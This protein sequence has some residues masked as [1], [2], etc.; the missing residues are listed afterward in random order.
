MKRAISLNYQLNCWFHNETARLAANGTDS[1]I[2]LWSDK[3]QTNDFR[4]IIIFFKLTQWIFFSSKNK[5]RN[6]LSLHCVVRPIENQPR[7]E[8]CISF[9]YSN[10]TIIIQQQKK[11]TKTHRIFSVWWKDI[12]SKRLVINNDCKLR[13]G[14]K[15]K[16]QSWFDDNDWNECSRRFECERNG[17]SFE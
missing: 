8:C 13:M 4:N 16:M 7:D 9:A 17:R 11:K 15:W 2:Y 5:N 6:L 3:K 12:S 10:Y 1:T 14:W